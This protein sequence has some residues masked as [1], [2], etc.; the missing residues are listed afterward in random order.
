MHLSA[1]I[2]CA[3]LSIKWPFETSMAAQLHGGP[4]FWDPLGF[5]CGTKLN[6]GRIYAPSLKRHSTFPSFPC[7]LATGGCFRDRRARGV[8]G[9]WGWTQHPA[10]PEA[11]A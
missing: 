8:I 5:W 7:M 6:L 11:L 10:P 1:H 4:C 2:P 9:S 3:D